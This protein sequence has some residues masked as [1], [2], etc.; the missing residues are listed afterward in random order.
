[1]NA[2]PP[3]YDDWKTTPP[4]TSEWTEDDDEAFAQMCEADPTIERLLGY[5]EERKAH[6]RVLYREERGL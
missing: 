2:M 6:L 3:C 1:M 4:P 5:V